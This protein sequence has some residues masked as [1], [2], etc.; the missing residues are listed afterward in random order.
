MS[1]F[2]RILQHV[3]THRGHG[4]LEEQTH[5]R[6]NGPTRST[7]HQVARCMGW[8]AQ[9]HLEKVTEDVWVLHYKLVPPGPHLTNLAAS[10]RL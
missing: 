4:S 8:S 6:A 3:C 9:T 2:D 1:E 7:V 10:P 5:Y